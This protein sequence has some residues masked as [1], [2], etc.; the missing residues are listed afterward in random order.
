[1]GDNTHVALPVLHSK[2]YWFGVRA[3]HMRQN[4]PQTPTST[5]SEAA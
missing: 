1:M 5:V 4:A 3:N 2:H